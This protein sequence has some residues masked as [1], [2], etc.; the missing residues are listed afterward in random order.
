MDILNED[1]G[2]GWSGYARSTFQ[3]GGDIRSYFRGCDDRLGANRSGRRDGRVV[4]VV[5]AAAMVVMWE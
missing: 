2:S 5:S 3:R 1:W 4:V